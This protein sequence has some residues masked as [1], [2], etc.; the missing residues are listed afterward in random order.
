MFDVSNS[1]E[2]PDWNE[3]FMLQ[4]IMEHRQVSKTALK[5]AVKDASLEWKEKLNLVHL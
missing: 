1:F 4:A 3:Y 5:G 2:R